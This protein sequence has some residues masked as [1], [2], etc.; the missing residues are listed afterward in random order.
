MAMV[1]PFQAGVERL[2][3]DPQLRSLLAGRSLAYLG[4]VSLGSRC[5]ASHTY[6][7]LLLTQ[8]ATSK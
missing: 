5:S 2:L 8:V 3:A 1:E 4:H 6:H 7:R